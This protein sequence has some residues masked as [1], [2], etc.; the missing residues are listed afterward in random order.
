M[1]ATDPPASSRGAKRQSRARSA[2][3][4]QGVDGRERCATIAG[5]GAKPMPRSRPRLMFW[6]RCIE[7]SAC[8]V[9]AEIHDHAPGRRR[10]SEQ[11]KGVMCMAMRCLLKGRSTCD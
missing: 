7:R 3:P 8:W 1:E 4:P 2:R 6:L 10:R 9:R 11:D 5:V